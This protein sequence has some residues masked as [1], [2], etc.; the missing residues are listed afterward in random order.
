MSLKGE[1]K[2]AEDG[3]A[4]YRQLLSRYKREVQSCN[5]K[6]LEVEKALQTGTGLVPLAVL[7]RD[8]E[9]TIAELTPHLTIRVEEVAHLHQM[10]S[11]YENHVVEMGT[12]LQ[13]MYDANDS[14]EQEV[15]KMK[16]EVKRVI[17][18]NDSLQQKVT[19]FESK[20]LLIEGHGGNKVDGGGA[21]G[22]SHENPGA[23]SEHERLDVENMPGD[24]CKDNNGGSQNY[25][26]ASMTTDS[27][28]VISR[29]TS[30]SKS[31]S[32]KHSAD[33]ES[34]Y[35]A[36]IEKEPNQV[37][38]VDRFEA[39]PFKILKPAGP[40]N[41]S[42]AGKRTQVSQP[43]STGIFSFERKSPPLVTIQPK[44]KTAE[45]GVPKDENPEEN[46]P[47]EK[48]PEE[49]A[50]REETREIDAPEDESPREKNLR[51]KKLKKKILKEGSARKEETPKEAPAASEPSRSQKRAV[52]KQQQKG[53]KK[54]EREAHSANAQVSRRV[55]Q[56]MMMR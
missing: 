18:A 43:T 15:R 8:R 14:L 41:P 16:K 32:G 46:M 55:Q 36:D 7:L 54:A 12:D 37:S 53:V 51:E 20:T 56:A 6:I 22:R 2:A 50:P 48:V 45:D 5:A 34:S 4:G 27:N 26:D 40:T 1:A 11:K 31:G 39:E 38:R 33:V 42:I 30:T 21:N 10:E 29:Q 17:R 19:L 23:S 28:D 49:G 35:A 44:E 52:K 13:C 47:K 24:S 3:I 9:K 25:D